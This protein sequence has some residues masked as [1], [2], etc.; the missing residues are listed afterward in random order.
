M[1]ARRY[2]QDAYTT[3]FTSSI[4]EKQIE[5][6][7]VALILEQTYFYPASGGQPADRGIVNG[8]P[9][10]DVSVREADGAVLHWLAVE[11]AGAMVEDTAVTATVDWDRRF[12]HMQQHTGQHILSQAFIRVAD[13]ET[14]G[15]HL[16][17]NSLTIDLDTPDL[18]RAQLAAAEQLANHIIWENR[19]IQV[20]FV[21]RQAAQTLPIRKIPDANGEE[22]RLIEIENFDLTACGGTHV[23]QTGSVGLIKLLKADKRGEK[24]RIEFVCGRRAWQDYGQKHH[25]VAALMAEFT[26]GAPQLLDAIRHLREET[27]ETQRLLKKEQ[28]ERQRLAAEHLLLTGSRVGRFTVI[29]HV[30][31]PQTGTN[32]KA[33]ALQLTQHAG[34]IVLLG[35]A[36]AKAQL[37]FA[38]AAD[39]RDGMQQLDMRA[40]LA[41]A[42]GLLGNGGGGGSPTFAQGGGPSADEEAIRGALAAAQTA[43]TQLLRGGVQ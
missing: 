39:A 31:E 11:W 12:D 37:L 9:V 41:M 10:L 23:A 33:L 8:V 30:V 5:G 6:D 14:V 27:K 7:R 1:S 17:D 15:F 38:C 35:M 18:T 20:R 22:L 13:A 2:Y 16:S 28:L 29:T 40:L 43:V 19:P 26:T 24:A 34:V 32:L 25:L 4:V 21:S 42:F 36:G 3:T